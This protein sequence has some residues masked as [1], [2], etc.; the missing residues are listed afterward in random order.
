MMTRLLFTF[1][2]L[3]LLPC[4]AFSQDMTEDKPVNVPFS[5]MECASAYEA[6]KKEL[7]ERREQLE[8]REEML[9]ELEKELDEKIARWE[10]L[11]EELDKK[12]A[13]F[14]EKSSEDFENLVEVYSTMRSSKAAAILNGMG[15]E[16]VAR[17]LKAMDSEK[18][19]DIV[20]RLD[21][22]KAVAVSRLLGRLK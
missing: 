10:T 3:A 20:P 19:A 22:E 4:S 17:I 14:E 1:L 16:N 7:T 12:L 18:V 13:L 15:S 8:Q 2:A 5:E 6:R 9:E 11:R 21:G